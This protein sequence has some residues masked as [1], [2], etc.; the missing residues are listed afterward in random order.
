[1][2]DLPAL[3]M[4]PLSSSGSWAAGRL[5]EVMVESQATATGTASS[6]GSLRRP[7]HENGAVTVGQAIQ[8]PMLLWPK[9]LYLRLERGLDRPVRGLNSDHARPGIGDTAR[10]ADALDLRTLLREFASAQD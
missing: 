6:V 1:M 4:T 9:P 7:A 8:P 2:P 10:L 5:P 3:A